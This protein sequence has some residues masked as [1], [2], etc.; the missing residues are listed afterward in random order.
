MLTTLI[1]ATLTAVA[2]LGDSTAKAAPTNTIC[3]VRG[4]SVTP[5]KSPIVTVRGRQYYLCCSECDGML[6][7]N[8]DQYLGKDG[9]PKNAKG[10]AAP[11][12][13][14]DHGTHQH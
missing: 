5:G 6:T 11:K 9:T 1:F 10:M 8:P 14:H 3:P 12:A 4:H 13:G 7:K 2:P